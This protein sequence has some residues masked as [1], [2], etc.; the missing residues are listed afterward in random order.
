M[1]IGL[2]GFGKTG[3][4]VA[5]VILNNPEMRLEWVVR[6]SDV[7]EHRSVPEF[8]GVESEAPGLIYPVSEF[9]ID[10]LLDTHPVD[11]IIDFSSED[12]I[13]YYGDAAAARGISI[14]SAISHYSAAKQRKLQELSIQTAILWSPNITIGINFLILAAQTLRRISPSIDIQIVEEHFKMKT[15]VSGTAKIIANSLGVD[16]SDVKSVRA[17]GIIGVH[18]VL[19]GF[20]SQTVRLRH[21]S[22]SRDAFGDGAVFAAERLDGLLP[23]LYKMEDLL[24]PYFGDD[25]SRQVARIHN[26]MMRLEKSRNLK[27]Q[28]KLAVRIPIGVR[29]QQALSG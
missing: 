28:A 15:E 18:E 14:V 29:E 6:K 17:G 19:F 13:D 10:E 9:P 16:E 27:R 12:G 1:R 11:A 4:A 24:L 5:A 8:F 21:E 22:I 20:P 25:Q 7:L 26:R 2:I 3:T 23:G